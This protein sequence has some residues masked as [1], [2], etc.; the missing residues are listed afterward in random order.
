MRKEESMRVALVDGKEQN[1]C[2]LENQLYEFDGIELTGGYTDSKVFLEHLEITEPEVVF[3]NAETFPLTGIQLS[4]E[5][6]ERENPPCIIIVADSSA[7]AV[8]AFEVQAVDY[9]LYPINVERLQK[10]LERVRSE[11]IK[12]RLLIK[13]S[14]IADTMEKELYVGSLGRFY[15][16]DT[17]GNQIKWRTKKVKEMFAYLWHNR[18]QSIYKALIIEDLWPEYPYDKAN[19]LFHTTMYQL[20]RL[21]KE[22]GFAE[23]I[24]FHNDAYKL[25]ISSVSDLEQLMGYLRIEN[26][27]K[28]SIWQILHLYTGDYFGEESYH[29]ADYE[30]FQYKKRVIGCLKRFVK[31]CWET[32][33]EDEIIEVCLNRMLLM[34]EGNEEY[35]YSL[36][37][38][39][40][41]KKNSVE[42][43]L[44]YNKYERLMRDDFGLELPDKIL[45]LYYDFITN[46]L[47]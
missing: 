38:W 3:I 29:W 32:T 19:S 1:I 36:L 6:N 4:R 40:Q 24:T 9:L 27:T 5:L 46:G 26:H 15:I 2:I 8:E 30:Q 39:Y 11:I 47:N 45:R 14:Q 23:A 17:Y 33:P 16:T 20:R 13:S 18:K 10:T 42:F 28:S 21:L 43:L 41:S 25:A 22:L 35:T 12:R 34:D 31:R 37:R 44:H 7:Y